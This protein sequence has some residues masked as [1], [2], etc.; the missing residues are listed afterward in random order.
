MAHR[1]CA[2]VSCSHLHSIS[3]FLHSITPTHFPLRSPLYS[4]V[5]PLSIALL[6]FSPICSLCRSH[7]MDCNWL[8]PHLL[9]HPPP[10]PFPQISYLCVSLSSSPQWISCCWPELKVT[11]W[12]G[13]RLQHRTWVLPL[14]PAR[15]LCCSQ[16][17][18]LSARWWRRELQ[19]RTDPINR[20]PADTA[21]HLTASLSLIAVI[22]C[23]YPISKY[24]LSHSLKQI[25][26]FSK[27][28]PRC[29]CNDN[30]GVFL[31]HNGM[32]H[33]AYS[34]SPLRTAPC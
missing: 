16:W 31:H 17:S 6:S 1:P 32:S 24:V 13:Q 14:L 33:Q 9:P 26:Y 27:N 19:E 18:C 34:C 22:L 8:Y 10:R 28:V 25:N 30:S 2:S 20:G 21:P 3:I 15:V 5:P 12:L 29:V 4:L 7:R 23:R 11:C